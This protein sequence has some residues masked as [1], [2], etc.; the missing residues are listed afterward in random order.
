[1]ILY[2]QRNFGELLSD[3]FQFF[4]TYGGNFFKNYLIINGGLLLLLTILIG[5]GFKDIIGQIF[6]S[7]TNGETYV[8]EEYFA[9]NTAMLI[10]VG[11]LIFIVTAII[12]IFSIS[13]PV[14]YMKMVARHS[15]GNFSLNAI[16]DEF[17]QNLGKIILFSVLSLFIFTPLMVL[18][19]LSS[20]LLAFLVIGIFLLILFVPVTIIIINFCLFDYLN[21][22]EGYFGALGNA[23]RYLFSKNFWKYLG[24]VVVVYLIVQATVGIIAFVPALILLIYNIEGSHDMA[25]IETKIMAFV[26]PLSTIAS[27][28]IS[29][30]LYVNTGLM[31]Y[32]SRKDLQREVH[33]NEID[34]IGQNA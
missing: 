11:G 4:R 13:Y 33:F 7:N 31:Y 32:D 29:N 30:L 19:A 18:A 23:F 8:L 27:L 15:Q 17:K 1:M 3:S 6:L 28:F 16:V 22:E 21:T 5:V 34:T 25:N 9:Q 24:N 26:S 10:I 2:K 14:L 20:F 12:W